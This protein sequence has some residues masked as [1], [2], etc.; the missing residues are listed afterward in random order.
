MMTR[1][2]WCVHHIPIRSLDKWGGK[3][4]STWGTA[5]AFPTSLLSTEPLVKYLQ[6]R[7]RVA[8][9]E[10]S[11]YAKGPDIISTSNTYKV[12]AR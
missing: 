2:A 6:G 10:L 1:Y 5:Q 11:P 8:F 9:V 12:F 3:T 4:F 7:G